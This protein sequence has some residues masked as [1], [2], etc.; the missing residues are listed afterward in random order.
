MVFTTIKSRI[1]SVFFTRNIIYD[2]DI[3]SEMID[4]VYLTYQTSSITDGKKES[5]SNELIFKELHYQYSH[6]SSLEFS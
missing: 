3:A 2:L 6:I 4:L 5:N 1:E